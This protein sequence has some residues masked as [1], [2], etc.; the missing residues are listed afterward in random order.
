[1]RFPRATLQLRR[2]QVVLMLAVLLPTIMMTA[3][4]IVLIRSEEHTSEL[5]SL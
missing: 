4:G 2:A 3:T 5:Q 1:M